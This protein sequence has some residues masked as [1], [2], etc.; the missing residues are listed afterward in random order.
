ME[1]P[2]KKLS[3]QAKAGITA[4]GLSTAF[5]LSVIFYFAQR[6]GP[7]LQVFVATAV[8]LALG[9]TAFWP[10]VVQLRTVVDETGIAQPKPLQ[11]NV[12]VRWDE[13]TKVTFSLDRLTSKVVS[14]RF[15][16]E[17]ANSDLYLSFWNK[18]SLLQ[19]LKMSIPAQ[20]EAFVRMERYW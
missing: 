2:Q 12:R 5:V 6:E 20:A 3:L 13:I 11:G 1:L 9:A 18:P 15:H 8:V 4:V 10:V 19:W 14:V 17:A 16:G 7:S